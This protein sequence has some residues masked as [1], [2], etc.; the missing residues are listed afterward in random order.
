MCLAPVRI[1][2][3]YREVNYLGSAFYQNVPCNDCPECRKKHATDFVTR[4]HFD[5]MATINQGGFIYLDTLTWNER[6]VHKHFKVRHFSHDDV[7][8]F[9]ANMEAKAI[10]K[11]LQHRGQSRACKNIDA[12]KA[13]YRSSC[14]PLLVE[15][16]GGDYHR[17]HIHL[18][19]FNRIPFFTPVDIEELVIT[20]WVNDKGVRLGG[21]ENKNPYFKLIRSSIGVGHYISDYLAKDDD[22][23]SVIKKRAKQIINKFGINS[24]IYERFQELLSSDYKPRRYY[25]QGFG[26]SIEEVYKA[27]DLL[28]RD[29]IAIPDSFKVKKEVPVP[30]YT[31]RR[32][33]KT[34]IKRPD[35]TYKEVW[36]NSGINY[37]IKTERKRYESVVRFYEGVVT[38]VDSFGKY[39]N[40]DENKNK[41]H[42]KDYYNS[43]VSGLLAGRC[44]ADFVLYK[45]YY[46]GRICDAAYS[47][48]NEGVET[49][50]YYQRQYS[51]EDRIKLINQPYNDDFRSDMYLSQDIR[52][53]RPYV[54]SEHNN[55]KWKDFDK[56]DSLFDSL[57]SAFN[58]Q[59]VALCKEDARTKARFRKLIK[60]RLH[61]CGI[62]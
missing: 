58:V 14:K 26:R 34:R 23:Y 2:P 33:F 30:A 17:P 5:A 12:A 60:S 32:L 31:I 39:L 18:S 62:K 38:S 54:I 15:E 46:K 41:V 53:F 36:N 42:I 8:R 9:K 50:S 51:F 43:R 57:V 56:L 40:Y 61:S 6:Q 44:I 28:A 11:I 20:S 22:Y 19:V 16:Y 27:S 13:L 4:Y 49:S 45:M 35:D 3:K 25:Y 37:V 29:K 48:V 55:T 21:I 52:A 7:K 24:K 1:I 59:Q 10:N 47:A